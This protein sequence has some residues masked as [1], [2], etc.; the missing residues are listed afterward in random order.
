MA[1]EQKLIFKP[2]I[3]ALFIAGLNDRSTPAFRARLLRL[4]I[5]VE[6]LLPGYEY[7]VWEAGIVEAVTLFP[8]LARA[9]ALEELG[10]RMVTANIDANP[11]GKTL[12]PL[13]RMMGMGRAIKRAL[14]RGSNENFNEVTFGAETSQS[15]EV[16]MSFVGTVPEFALGTLTG[17]ATALG[18]KSARAKVLRFEKAAAAYQLEWG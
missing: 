1:A 18:A 3:E 16:V 7:G 6:K 17:L 8:E 9:A 15:L 10:R 11:V 4:G 13:L 14:T 12:L 5:N 2:V